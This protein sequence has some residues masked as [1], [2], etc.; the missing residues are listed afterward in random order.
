M[1]F[2]VE[3]PMPKVKPPKEEQKMSNL[4][5]DFNGLTCQFTQE[6]NTLG[7]T[8]NIEEI[9]ISLETQLPGE[10]PFIVIKTTTGWSFDNIEELTDLIKKCLC[11]TKVN[12]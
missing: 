5:P 12:Q 6:G 11:V 2:E 3:C 9:S 8:D 4:K 7:T 10:E 1:K